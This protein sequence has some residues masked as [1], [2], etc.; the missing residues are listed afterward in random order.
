ML[1]LTFLCLPMTANAAQHVCTQTPCPV[2]QV[3]DLINGLPE[4]SQITIQNAASIIDQIHAID[5]LKVELTDEQYDELLTKVAQGNDGSGYGTAVPIRY[6]EAVDALTSLTGGATLY[7]VKRFLAA[8]GQTVDLSDAQVQLKITNL[9]TAQ[10]QTVTL[11][12]LDMSPNTLAGTGSFYSAAADGWTYKYILAPGTYKIEESADS[13][14]TVNGKAFVTGS[15][16]YSAN[17]QTGSQPLTLTVEA[18]KDYSVSILNERA[19]TD[20]SVSFQD[21][22]GNPISGAV[23]TMSNQHPLDLGQVLTFDDNT[24]TYSQVE[25]GPF[26][27]ALTQVPAGYSSP[28]TGLTFNPF[29]SINGSHFDGADIAAQGVSL[30]GDMLSGFTLTFSFTEN[31]A[32]GPGVPQPGPVPP[33]D[34]PNTGD[35]DLPLLWGALALLSLVGLLLTKKLQRNF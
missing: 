28:F 11:S 30:S 32:G 15:T 25:G 35:Y 19:K 10:S 3:A 7:P 21:Q 5:R 24:S 23:L 8:D 16:T 31:S 20:L 18:G 27:L 17:G 14:A 2:C 12:T 6:V 13:G 34:V 29:S 33:A 9:S 22:N 4:K 1:A 26:L